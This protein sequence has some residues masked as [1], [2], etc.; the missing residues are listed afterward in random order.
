MN[1][2]CS[3]PWNRLRNPRYILKIIWYIKSLGYQDSYFPSY[4]PFVLLRTF[5]KWLKVVLNLGMDFGTLGTFLK[6]FSISLRK[7]GTSFIKFDTSLK[8]FGSSNPWATRTPISLLMV[9]FFFFFSFRDP[10]EMIGGRS[11][12]WNRLWN[13]K[14]IFKKIWFFGNPR[15]GC[16]KFS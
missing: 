15:I 1:G 11:P 2:G 12:P 5:G 16:T 4:G 8:E 14:Y 7:F 9:F 13:L 3:S 6:K 10:R